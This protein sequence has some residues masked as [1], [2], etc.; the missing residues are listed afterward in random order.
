MFVLPHVLTGT[1]IGKAWPRARYALPAAFVSHLVLDAIPH[2]EVTD[3]PGM[4][5][6]TKALL[7]AVAIV[8]S[9]GLVVGLSWP[10][11]HRWVMIGA[12]ACGI[13]LDV[14]N[15][16]GP[17]AA[18]FQHSAATAWFSDFHALIQRNWHGMSIP[19][20]LTTQAV[21]IGV[22][23]WVILRR[24]RPLPPPLAGEGEEG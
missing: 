15:Y 6:E 3:I 11:R 4:P 8:V 7:G 21:V 22:A 19:L 13:L 10:Q 24:P 1:A 17:W 12:G 23:L 16:M 5:E 18:W 14:I 9:V 2:A 20:G